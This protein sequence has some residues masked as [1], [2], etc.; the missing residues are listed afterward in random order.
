MAHH[1]QQQQQQQQQ[2]DEEPAPACPSPSKRRRTT[3]GF[4]PASRTGTG[5]SPGGQQSVV[6]A[7]TPLSTVRSD[8]RHENSPRPSLRATMGEIGFLSRSAMAESRNGSDALPTHLKL[9]SV[10]SGFLTMDGPDPS[11]VAVSEAQQLGLIAADGQCLVLKRCATIAYLHLFLDRIAIQFPHLDQD[12]LIKQYDAVTDKVVDVA[13]AN[14]DNAPILWYFTASLAVA[15]GALIS[16]HR[17]SLSVF[18]SSLRS[19]AANC[20]GVI[21]SSG[22]GVAVVHAM[23]M[24]TLLATFS[25]SG[26]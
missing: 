18:V 24:L 7:G 3:A 16:T 21:F 10:V 26:G 19:S 12:T 20:L 1:E 8:T 11:R 13:K 6:A 15:M 9:H 14:E 25:P 17:S 2:Q 23:L 4:S 22:D 5:P